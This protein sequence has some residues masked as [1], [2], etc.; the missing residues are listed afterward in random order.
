[1]LLLLDFIW[2]ITNRIVILRILHLRNCLFKEDRAG[3]GSNPLGDCRGGECTLGL[4]GSY[5]EQ[6]CM[7][8]ARGL[9]AGGTRL[10]HR[11]QIHVR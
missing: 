9:G 7:E 11:L 5:R 8:T 6:A 3:E 10:L 2:I 4:V 1:M